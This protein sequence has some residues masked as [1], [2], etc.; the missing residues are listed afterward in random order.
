MVITKRNV[1]VLAEKIEELI[2]HI[3]DQIKDLSTDD[4]PC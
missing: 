3:E 2:Q 1:E 4:T